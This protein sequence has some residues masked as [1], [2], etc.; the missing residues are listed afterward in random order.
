VKSTSLKLGTLQY[1]PSVHDTLDVKTYIYNDNR[2]RPVS[3]RPSSG[4]YVQV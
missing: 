1:T 2:F 3:N 4:P